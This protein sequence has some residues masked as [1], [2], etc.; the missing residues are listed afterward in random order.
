LTRRISARWGHAPIDDIERRLELASRQTD[1]Q[2]RASAASKKAERARDGE[3]AMAEYRAESRA[4]Q[5][6]MARLRTLRLAR[7]AVAPPPT[8]AVKKAT[9]PARKAA[10]P[11]RKTG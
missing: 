10:T 8:A 1:D 7:D 9:A 3:K 5:E 11:G 6:K 2:A 4:V